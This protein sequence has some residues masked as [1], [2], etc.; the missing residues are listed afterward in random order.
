[1]WRITGENYDGYDADST[2]GDASGAVS[3]SFTCE[4]LTAPLGRAASARALAT[5]HFLV[6]TKTAN[7]VPVD[8]VDWPLMTR[9]GVTLLMGMLTLPPP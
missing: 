3:S 4:E 1:M 8:E 7:S 6:T 9:G 2:G 5:S